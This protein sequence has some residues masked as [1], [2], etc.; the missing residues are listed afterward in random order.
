MFAAFRRRP[1]RSGFGLGIMLAMSGI[2][3]SGM[4]STALA[5]DR[6]IDGRGNN[7]ENPEWGAA[8]TTELRIA[9]AAYADGVS[10]IGGT[11]RPNPRVVSNAIAAQSRSVLSQRGLS[12]WIWQWGQFIDHDLTFSDAAT[13]EEVMSIAIPM[14]DPFFDPF[15]TGRVV[16]EQ[17]RSIFDP[18][19]GSGPDNP[20]EQINMLTAFVDGSGVYGSDE[21]RAAWL[22]TF[23]GGRLKVSEGDLLPLNDGTQVMG[24]P[25]NL[26]SFATDLFVAGDIRANEQVGLISVHTLWVREHN[27]LADELAAAHPDWD[28]E[29]IYQRARK[30]VGAMI[31]NI[32]YREFLPALLGPHAPDPDDAEYDPTLDPSIDNVFANAS[33]RIGHTMLS[34]QIM[35]MD[36]DGKEMEAGPISLRDAFFQPQRIIHEGGIEP[37]LTGLAHQGAQEIDSMVIDDVRNF[38]FG[39][40]GSGGMD[41]V[42]LNIQRGREHGL[43]DYNTVRESYGLPKRADFDEVTKDPIVR[44]KLASVYASPNQIDPWIGGVVEDQLEGASVGELIATVLG[45]Q[46]RRLR[47]GDRFWYAWDEEFTAEDIRM[48]ERTRLSDVIKRNSSIQKLQKNVFFMD[49]AQPVERGQDTPGTAGLCGAMGST[50]LLGMTLGLSAIRGRRRRG[51]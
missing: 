23:D 6:S 24:G 28:D 17:K 48:L 3:L 21:E 13:P 1:T 15:A 42:S 12:D 47:D 43:P 29:R 14:G 2:S 36:D 32:T 26:P 44:A 51:R 9:P 38:L 30:L 35:R 27:R 10:A 49:H 18:A 45:D 41:L 16:I 5:E 33:Y 50:G 22:R 8:F 20:R 25:G 4:A 19:T 39:P 31:Q 11:D 46:F 40:P 7:I 34:P 37:V